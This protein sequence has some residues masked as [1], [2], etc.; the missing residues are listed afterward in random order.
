MAIQDLDLAIKAEQQKRNRRVWALTPEERMDR[1][2]ALQSLAEQTLATNPVALAAFHRRNRQ[3]RTAA[4]VREL[5][6]RLLQ[7]PDSQDAPR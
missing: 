2:L 6:A 5:V 4:R 1:Y 3:K 7:H